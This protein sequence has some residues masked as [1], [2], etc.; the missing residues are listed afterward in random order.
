MRLI[1]DRDEIAKAQELFARSISSRSSSTIPISIGYQSGQHDT[2]VYWI[3]DLGYWA[4]FGFPP[5]GKSTGARYWNVFGLGKPSGMV[6]IVCEIN[7]PVQGVNRQAAGGFVLDTS[8]NIHLIH[9]GIL[10]ARGRIKKDFVFRNFDGSF[11]NINDAGQ[12]SKVIHIGGLKDEKLPELVRDFI[13]EANKIKDLV[14]ANRG[15]K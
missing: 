11:T 13:L 9:R 12:S 4:Y 1:T 5:S 3:P 6:S 15:G 10:N 8:G 14:R 2:K 7:P